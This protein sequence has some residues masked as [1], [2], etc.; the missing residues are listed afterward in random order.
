MLFGRKK[1]RR[2]ADN[3]LAAAKIAATSSLVPLTD[4]LPPLQDLVR[5]RGVDLWDQGLTIAAL[6]AQ[7]SMLGEERA[8]TF[9]RE[10]QR[11]VRAWNPTAWDAYLDLLQF[12]QRTTSGGVEYKD[13]LGAWVVWNLKGS[14]PTETELRLASVIGSF[15][16]GTISVPPSPTTSTEA[17]RAEGFKPDYGL[18]L[19]NQGVTREVEQ[20]FYDFRLFEISVVGRDQYTTMVDFPIG[21]EVYALSVDFNARIFQQILERSPRHIRERIKREL[22]IDP[23]TPRRIELPE[24]IQCG[25]VARLG[26]KQTVAKC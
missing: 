4:R 6:A 26:T 17:P 22:A 12:V 2:E 24:P 21:G 18:F 1:Q 23:A 11:T 5:D 19:A 15:L 3:V 25:V 7:V 9:M 20:F 8:A 16:L 13:A 10:L 14:T